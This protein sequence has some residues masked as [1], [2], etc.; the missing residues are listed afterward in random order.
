MTYG[1]HTSTYEWN[2]DDISV[3]TSDIPLH[4][5]LYEWHT[6]NIQVYKNDIQMIYEYIQIKHKHT[7]VTCEWHTIDIR[8]TC[9]WHKKHY[10]NC[11]KDLE[12]LDRYSC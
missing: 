11:I 5:S 1:W 9:E 10:L 2:M 12:I 7:Q 3:Y 6:D 4:T 8:I